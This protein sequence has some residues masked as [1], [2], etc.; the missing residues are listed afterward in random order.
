M[1]P[2][3]A[4]LKKNHYSSDYAQSSYVSGPDL[5]AEIGH[6]LDTLTRQDMKNKKGVVFFWKIVGYDG[7]HIDLLESTTVDL[8]CHSH[9]YFKCKEVW[10]WSLT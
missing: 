6:D 3:Y 9:C 4:E 8:L 5:Y 10:F 7:G 2:V 1:T